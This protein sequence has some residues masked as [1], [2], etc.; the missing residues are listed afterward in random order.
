MDG[1]PKNANKRSQQETGSVYRKETHM[2]IHRT[3]VMV[4]L[5]IIFTINAPILADALEGRIDQFVVL[6]NGA[7]YL[8]DPF[9]DGHPPCDLQNPTV[10]GS[11]RTYTCRGVF[12]EGGGKAT[13]NSNDGFPTFGLAGSLLNVPVLLNNGRLNSNIDPL[14]VSTGGLKVDDVLEIR[15]LFDLVVPGEKQDIYG[16]TFTDRAPNRNNEGNDNVRLN[17]L[18]TRISGQNVVRFT[19]SDFITAE[20]DPA[21]DVL[22]DPNHSQILLVLTRPGNSPDNREVHAKFAYVDSP[23]DISGDLSGL[24]FIQM[25]NIGNSSGNPITI[26]NGEEYTRAEFRM[27]VRDDVRAAR[28][29]TGS[30]SSMSRGV[31]T[32]NNPF[33]FTFDYRFETP[34]GVLT[35]SLNNLPLATIP[36]PATVDSNFTHSTINVNDAD[37]GTLLQGLTNV[38]LKFEIDSGVP[39]STILIDNI[40][41]PG[42]PNENFADG[43]TSNWETE[44]T[45]NVLVIES[46]EDATIEITKTRQRNGKFDIRGNLV[47]SGDSDGLN[48]PQNV[49]IEIGSISHTIPSAAFVRTSSNDGFQLDGKLPGINQLK[50][51]DDGRIAISGRDESSNIDFQN[52]V[53]LL[54]QIGND[55]GQTN[56]DF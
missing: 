55:L 8:N 52:P 6:K 56:I 49:Q 22:L 11:T 40:A 13:F 38:T 4:F 47:L 46:P 12:T 43:T 41:F 29:V 39:G 5:V 2:K 17:V 48:M 24:T 37:D 31:N 53:P 18:K 20:V 35:V 54:L 51:W 36:A 25:D 15:G 9:T 23:R 26:F 19:K 7:I 10:E 27:L 32:P 28:L 1:T 21:D 16:I 3:L 50:I 33:S 14:S 34:T 42:L 45:V 30:P 44:G